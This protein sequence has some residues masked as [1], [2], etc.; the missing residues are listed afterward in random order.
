MKKNLALFVPALVILLVLAL[1]VTPARAANNETYTY[2]DG[3]PHT[4]TGN[5]NVGTNAGNNNFLVVSNATVL[6]V[7]GD[8]SIS[9]SYFDTNNRA[10]IA[11]TG[12]AWN[13]GGTLMVGDSGQDAHLVIGVFTWLHHPQGIVEP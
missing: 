13:V 11:G 2:V 8:S 9:K 1:G 4:I 12:S 3:A 6:N 5:F 7:T 10:L